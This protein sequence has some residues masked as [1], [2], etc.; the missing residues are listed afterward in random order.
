MPVRDPGYEAGRSIYTIGHSNHPMDRLIDLLEAHD[1][2]VLVDVRSQ[3]YSRY[4]PQFDKRSLE[5][6]I[7]VA[8]LKYLY[9]GKEL[10]GRPDGKE[11]YDDTGR[12]RYS[13]VAK[14]PL[15]LEGAGRLEMGIQKYRVAMLCSEEDPAGCHRRLLV[16]H[17]L[18]GKGVKVL[19]IRGDGSVQA[20]DR[21][22]DADTNAHA[23]GQ[24]PL[25]GGEEVRERKSIRSVLPKE[26]RRTSL[27]R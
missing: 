17:F 1:V 4:A 26:R 12:V 2:E 25:F 18:H 15:F 20:E 6:A 16:G 5:A 14:S 3:P 9:L 22:G 11:F 27:E 13:E 24:L 21:L 7:G 19:H 23:N 8:G 10:G